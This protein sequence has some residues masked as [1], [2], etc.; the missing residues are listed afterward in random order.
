MLCEVG[1]WWQA[2]PLSQTAYTCGAKIVSHY[3]NLFNVAI[4]RV[5]EYA[6]AA[7]AAE[8]KGTSRDKACEPGVSLSGP[9]S[10]DS[11][12]GAAVAAAPALTTG[13][14]KNVCRR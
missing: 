7:A 14:A 9:R 3:I 1:I 4:G 2:E 12:G 13:A 10:K 11:M 6:A 8:P 5:S